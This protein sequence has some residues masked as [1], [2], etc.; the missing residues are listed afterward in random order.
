MKPHATP[1]VAGVGCPSTHLDPCGSLQETISRQLQPQNRQVRVVYRCWNFAGK[2]SLSLT[3]GDPRRALQAAML[4]RHVVAATGDR[5]EA[6]PLRRPSN[7]VGQG[8]RKV[9]R[10]WPR[11]FKTS[12]VQ[13]I[14]R[15][16]SITAWAK[17]HPPEN[18]RWRSA[19]RAA[20]PRYSD[21][22]GCPCHDDASEYPTQS[23]RS[24]HGGATG[25]ST[26][27]RTDRDGE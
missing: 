20:I 7:R 27:R 3:F 5:P 21:P 17:K 25:S 18:T 2:V 15:G 4:T 23:G 1:P 22:A 8:A 12:L 11:I 10:L 14:A 6:R 13:A 16:Q 9:P 24:L 19:G 26:A